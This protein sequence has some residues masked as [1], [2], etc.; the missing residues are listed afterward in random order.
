[1]KKKKWIIC[2][3]IV[4][5][6][7]ALPRITLYFM[8]YASYKMMNDAMEPTLLPDDSVLAN[9]N[10]Y[11]PKQGD[12]IVFS[13]PKHID[14]NEKNTHID[15][16][17]RIIGLPGD[18][19]QLKG[20]VLY[21]NGAPVKMEPTSTPSEYIEILP[22]GT[23]YTI[24]KEGATGNTILGYDEEFIIPKDHYFVLG[25]NR[26]KSTDEHIPFGSEKYKPTRGGFV[27]KERVN[28]YKRAW[29]GLVAKEN[30]KW[31]VTILCFSPSRLEKHLFGF[32]F[33]KIR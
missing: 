26:D 18:H 19:I 31:P 12:V 17:R 25:D 2:F 8:S 5:G 6:L 4:L 32:I 7:L 21:L 13:N 24:K 30:I 15:C 9:K 28:R 10:V 3:A 23:S 22:N 16:V 11:Q 1:M 27:S 33:K 29:G 14:K 20:G